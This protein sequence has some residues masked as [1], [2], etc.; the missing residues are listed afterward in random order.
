M[1]RPST[2]ADPTRVQVQ[3]APPNERQRPGDISVHEGF[4]VTRYIPGPK[5]PA[6]N[7]DANAIVQAIAIR[8]FGT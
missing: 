7:T 2:P 5:Q 1:L 3:A 6:S 4:G 8:R